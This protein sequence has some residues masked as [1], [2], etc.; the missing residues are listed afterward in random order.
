MGRLVTEKEENKGTV[1]KAGLFWVILALPL[2]LLRR[3][4][5]HRD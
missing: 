4:R 1:A 3:L 2:L 5:K